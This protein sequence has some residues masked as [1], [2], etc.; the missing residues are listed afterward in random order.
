MDSAA[1]AGAR[2]DGD[3]VE[4]PSALFDASAFER[5]HLRAHLLDSVGQAVIATDLQG[6]ILYWNRVAEEVYGW[7]ADEALGR[8]VLTLMPT[9][10]TQAQAAEIMQRLTAG[11][12]WTGE[13]TVRRKDGSSLLVMVT[14]TPV[15]DESGALVG[16]IGISWDLT[17]RKAAEH[18][19]QAAY[20]R[21]RRAVAER[22]RVLAFV[23]HDLRNPLHTITMAS[24][25]LREDIPEEKK[26]A[27]IN[28]IGRAARQMTRLIEDLL[29]LARI[30]GGGLGIAPEPC[31]CGELVEAALELLQPLAES[32]RL[33]LCAEASCAT[34]VLADR[35]RIIQ[36]FTNLVSNA[37]DHTPAGGSIELRAELIDGE[38]VLSV[39][40]TG[41]GI[42]AEDVAFVFDRFW[43]AQ[44]MGGNG[45]GLGLAIVKG[46][47]EAHHGRV[48]VESELGVGTTFY[49]TLP[50]P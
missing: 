6:R 11:E 16:I 32:R 13:F 43:R 50:N 31:D 3:L 49:F 15:R 29:D 19:I 1:R 30:D 46:I 40:D 48:W 24:G 34:P 45:A 22:D 2:T 8:D 5:I 12:S 17:A 39:R 9:D 27:H 10:A 47:V 25:L 28:I 44:A 26:Q 37:V 18:E 35:E 33:E 42:P 14:D 36:V 23:S 7:S 4:A 21:T 41:R 38:A 20:E